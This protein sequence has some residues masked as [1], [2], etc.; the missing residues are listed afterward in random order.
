MMCNV[1]AL[2]NTDYR[3]RQQRFI[4]VPVKVADLELT[5]ND[6]VS[7]APAGSSALLSPPRDRHTVTRSTKQH[8]LLLQPLHRIFV[9]HASGLT[10]S[11]LKTAWSL[12]AAEWLAG[13]ISIIFDDGGSDCELLDV[14]TPDH[15][16]SIDCPSL[17][18]PVSISPFWFPLP[19]LPTL[20]SSSLLA[21]FF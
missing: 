16:T 6:C 10:R 7:H 11:P 13:C 3:G 4:S 19:N 5:G 12:F 14:S 20:N 1:V 17:S 21:V 9:S 8:Q 2:L 18:L 15:L